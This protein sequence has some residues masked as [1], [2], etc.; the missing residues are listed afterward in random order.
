MVNQE[1]YEVISQTAKSNIEAID[2]VV[3]G[4]SN[5]GKYKVKINGKLWMAKIF[6][7][8]PM[9][10][11][12]Y[13]ELSKLSGGA[14]AVPE[15]CHLFD[16]SKLCL[17]TPWIEGE[18]LETKLVAATKSEIANYGMQA[19][20]IAN[21]I[22]Q[23]LKTVSSELRVQPAAQ[24]FQVII[25]EFSAVGS[26][27][28]IGLVNKSRDANMPV[29]LTTQALADL[30]QHSPTLQDQLLGIVNSFI[31]HRANKFDDAEEL[32][33]LSGKIIRKRFNEAVTYK[34]G[35]L[36][37]GSAVGTGTIEDVEE[38][39]ILPQDIQSLGTGEFYYINKNPMRVVHGN[40]II[41]DPSMIKDND[42]SLNV[43]FVDSAMFV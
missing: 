2:N 20:L 28:I 14:L 21:L 17:I 10:L 35:F 32:A 1:I 11:A 34:T 33:G 3:G 37:R 36:S 18:S 25:D 16:E 42:S 41:E 31:I 24:P 26:E 8:T 39:T 15:M 38:S 29:T 13:K 27:H 22:I 7:G 19:A 40:C 23:D 12:W 30:R 6:D 43:N 5:A 9:R 4:L